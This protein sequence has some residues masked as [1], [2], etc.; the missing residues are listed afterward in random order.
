MKGLIHSVENF[1]TVDGPGIR[2][3]LFLSGCPMQCQ[4][5]DN[6]DTAWS[7]EGRE[8][9]PQRVLAKYNRNRPFYKKG[10]VTFSGGEPLLQGEFVDQCAQL[11][12]ANKA[13]VAIDTSLCCGEQWVEKLIPD[14]NLWMVSIKAA[15]PALHQKFT[16]RDNS[17]IM[18]NIIKLN[19]AVTKKMLIRYVIIPGYTDNQKEL[20]QLAKFIKKLPFTPPLQLLAYHAM[21]LHKWKKMQLDYQLAGVPDAHTGDVYRAGAVLQTY[22]ISRFT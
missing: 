14:V 12:K 21:G 4:F 11:L 20:H 3:V 6:P 18:N 19:K 17:A 5:C 2:L 10:G 1:G 15:T 8:H 16:G 7:N 13:H 9:T 22:G